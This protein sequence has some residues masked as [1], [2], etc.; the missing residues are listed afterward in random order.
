MY[1]TI[2]QISGALVNIVLDDVFIFPLDMG[3]AGAAWATIIGQFVSLFVA[4]TFH[5]LANREI[6]G[7][8]K[9]IKPN[10][11]IIGEIYKIG[12]SAAMMQAVDFSDDGGNERDFGYVKH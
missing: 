7:G 8:I 12:A 6:G 5:Y 1:S 10:S 9:Y 3:G 2:S 11:T 4:M